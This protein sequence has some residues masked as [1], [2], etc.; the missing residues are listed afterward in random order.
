[1]P[2]MKISNKRSAISQ[3]MDLFI[4]IAAVLAAGGVVVTALSG[5]IGAA[6]SQSNVT[7]TGI[8][9]ASAGNSLSLTLKN[10]GTSSISIGASDA[11]TISG[12]SVT[13]ST[14]T[15]CPAPTSY[16]GNTAVSWTGTTSAGAC[17]VAGTATSI[18]FAASGPVSLLP[19]QLL[20]FTADPVFSSSVFTSGSSYTVAITG[21]SISI[22]ENVVSQ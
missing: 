6:A 19:G 1:M 9:V 3:S 10:T 15:S 17:N 5:L 13:T 12:L 16:A 2:P 21:P 22:S 8:S 18:K 4:I 11:I 14:S 7:L 20:S